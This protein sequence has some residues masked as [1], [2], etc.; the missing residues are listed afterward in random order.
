MRR[1]SAL[2]LALWAAACAHAPPPPPLLDTPVP[3]APTPEVARERAARA[4]DAA[5]AADLGW[6]LGNDRLAARARLDDALAKSGERKDPALLLRRARLADAELREDDARRDLSALLRD[7][8]TSAEAALAIARLGDD[9]GDSPAERAAVVEAAQAA[10]LGPTPLGAPRVAQLAALVARAAP[11]ATAALDPAVV[12]RA[13]VVM[14]ARALG[15][16][17]PR[18]LASLATPTAPELEGIDAPAPAHLGLVPTARPAFVHRGD[19]MPVEG[20]RDGLYLLE[21]Y[22]VLDQPASVALTVDLRTVGRVRVDGAV[23]LD[24]SASEALPAATESVVVELEA[25]PHRVTVAL[26]A[27]RADA[28]RLSLLGVDGAPLIARSTGELLPGLPTAASRERPLVGRAMRSELER[29]LGD[30]TPADQPGCIAGDPWAARALLADL[31]M[32]RAG[33][34][35]EVAR[36]LVRALVRAAPRSAVAL[37]LEA[38]LSA[39][40]GLPTSRADAALRRALVEDPTHPGLLL[41]AARQVEGDDP[42]AAMAL[43]DRARAAVPGAVEPELA[44]FRV[45]RSRGWNAEA[46]ASLDA[47]LARAR[48]PAILEEA[49]R[50]HRTLVHLTQARALETELEAMLPTDHRAIAQALQRGELDA[51]I[52]KLAAVAPE[53]ARPAEVWRRIAELELGRARPKEALAHAE[54]ALASE[55]SD[56]AAL[57]HALVAARALGDTARVRQLLDRLRALGAADLELELYAAELDGRV[58]GTEP[59]GSWLAERLQL[60][61]IALASAPTD[62]RW[63]G[64]ARVRLLERI[65][66]HVRADGSA[67]S[68]H[69]QLVRL[70]TKEATDVAGEIRLPDGALPLA[71]RT[72]KRDGRTVEV[73]R[74]A[75]KEDLSFS[76]LAPGDAVE[77]EWIAVAGPSSVFGGYL[78]RFL[79]QTDLP[80]ARAELVVVVPKGQSVWWKSYHGAP[81]PEIHKGATHDTYLFAARDVPGIPAEPA[82][83]PIEEFL[84]FVVLAIG[85]D[86][87]RAREANLAALG[88]IARPSRDVTTLTASVTA[89]LTE[90]AAIIERVTRWVDAR[91]RDGRGDAT[92]AA[93]TGEGSQIALV[94]AM[95][96]ASGL[97]ARL[98]LA[99]SGRESK[100]EPPFP[101][102]NRYDELLL[103]VDLPG[104]TP[105]GAPDCR[106][107]IDAQGPTLVSG[108]APQTYRG[109][110]YVVA[111][112][113]GDGAAVPFADAEVGQWKVRSRAQLEL[114][115]GGNLSGQIEVV[116]PGAVGAGV[117]Q[118]FRP[119]RLEDVA[120]ALQGWLNGVLPGAE[121]VDLKLSDLAPSA[122]D[123]T[124]TVAVRASA[125]LDEEAGS[126]V[127]RR[128]FEGPIGLRALGVRPLEAYLARSQRLMPMALDA[129]AEAMEVE[130]RLAPELGAPVDPPATFQVDTPW[131]AV[132]QRFVWDPTT[133]T[134]RLSLDSA[135]K[136]ARVA[137]AEYPAFRAMAQEVTLRTRNRLVLR[138]P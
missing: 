21:T 124:M 81:E 60:D 83:A 116:L 14:A 123:L 9:P 19:L 54:Q 61:P 72:I 55:P 80:T 93:L 24:R 32:S 16:L 77:Q 129:A 106:R 108:L 56:T 82:M 10:L 67:L 36:G 58:I 25:G 126:R 45:L 44:R 63:S 17:G 127:L 91:I 48:R 76:A 79:F 71:L 39:L 120:R 94:A 38:R 70:A 107:W 50:Y 84:P 8:P 104:C 115:A 114:D 69:H 15:P 102:P 26:L 51:A 52:A 68:L 1:A 62:P 20:D 132:S 46:T 7:S 40:E 109:G 88:P 73:D 43:I 103:R 92:R 57:R 135:L 100:V 66:E 6:I 33:R 101:D 27:G 86:E 3:A 137:P 90:P 97:D 5:A 34:D 30:C 13:G 64:A 31:A 112:P 47:V 96:R 89:G 4:G 74:H 85:L 53:R 11:G 75:G 2:L 134:A 113:P 23:V 133:R 131:A 110:S 125:V 22:F 122:D 59:A 37:T 42:E 41:A 121:L 111:D 138:R 119:M 130:V 105:L 128:F 117:R 87:A 118:S 95:L 49:A 18:T 29:A 28:V 99:R 35:V 78:R 136:A 12:T 98:V 65:V